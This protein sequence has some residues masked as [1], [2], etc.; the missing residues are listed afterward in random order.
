M[1]SW[2]YRDNCIVLIRGSS[3]DDSINNGFSFCQR[4]ISTNFRN[5]ILEIHFCPEF[6]KI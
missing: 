3:T 2:K 6:N 4:A 1:S 5:I